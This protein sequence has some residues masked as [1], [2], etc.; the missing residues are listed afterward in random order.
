MTPDE[1]AAE[2]HLKKVF[3]KT[4]DEAYPS[5]SDRYH[6]I[7]TFLAGIAHA[8]R[9]IDKWF[10]VNER[11]PDQNCDCWIALT[12]STIERCWF[13]VN[14]AVFGRDSYSMFNREAVTHWQYVEIIKPPLPQIPTVEGEG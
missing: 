5:P 12:D 7:G 2:A 11:L 9:P 10:D 4:F 13:F 6:F 14:E 8:R 3:G 1:I